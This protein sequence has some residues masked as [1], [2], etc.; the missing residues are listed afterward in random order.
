M[1]QLKIDGSCHHSQIRSTSKEERINADQIII[2]HCWSARFHQHWKPNCSLKMNFAMWWIRLQ[3]L[4]VIHIEFKI[5]PADTT[6]EMN[7][8]VSSYLFWFLA[9]SRHWKSL[10]I[11]WLQHSA[12]SAEHERHQSHNSIESMHVC[13]VNASMT[14]LILRRPRI[15]KCNY[16]E[17]MI[18]WRFEYCS[19]RGF[20]NEARILVPG[21]VMV[22]PNLFWWKDKQQRIDGES[23]KNCR[24]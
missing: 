20:R 9:F 17:G 19:V 8:L 4:E 22:R 5:C 2:K 7:D 23:G 21:C 12:T 10:S 18:S 11:S 3:L 24:G 15:L 14:N 1:T 16:R 6:P 13:Q